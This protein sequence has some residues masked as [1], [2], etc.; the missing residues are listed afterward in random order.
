MSQDKVEKLNAE[1]YG[2]EGYDVLRT[3]MIEA[4]LNCAEA[5]IAKRVKLVVAADALAEAAENVRHWHDTM[6]NP[7]TK[8]TEGVI[9]SAKHWR[10]MRAALE[11]YRKQRG[12]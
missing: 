12:E 4:A 2:T 1:L 3:S 6:Y 8:E 11:T 10:E 7:E 9:V 5:E